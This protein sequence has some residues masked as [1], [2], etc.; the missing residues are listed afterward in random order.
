MS[1][2][3][4]SRARVVDGFNPLEWVKHIRFYNKLLLSRYRFQFISEI[5]YAIV[6]LGTFF[7]FI[8]QLNYTA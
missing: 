5:I 1:S 3:L 8:S 6:L 2:Q 4:I 7:L